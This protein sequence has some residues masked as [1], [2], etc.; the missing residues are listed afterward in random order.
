MS[1]RPPTLCIQESRW[2]RVVRG[3]LSS[4]PQRAVFV[5]S[6]ELSTGIRESLSL[7]RHR[8]LQHGG[9]AAVS[10]LIDP[11]VPSPSLLTQS[12]SSIS[13]H[14]VSKTTT[15][16][17][18]PSH[19]NPLRLCPSPALK[20]PYPQPT[21]TKPL[22][23]KCIRPLL[24]TKQIIQIHATALKPPNA[25]RAIAPTLPARGI[26]PRVRA[27]QSQRWIRC[28]LRSLHQ[29]HGH[30]AEQLHVVVRQPSACCSSVNP[31]HAPTAAAA[32]A[33]TGPVRAHRP[34]GAAAQPRDAAEDALHVARAAGAAGAVGEVRF[35]AVGDG[36]GSG[37]RGVFEW[38]AAILEGRHRLVWVRERVGGREH[39]GGHVRQRDVEADWV[40]EGVCDGCGGEGVAGCLLWCVVWDVE[41]EGAGKGG[42]GGEAG[43]CVEEVVG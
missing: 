5:Q 41:V 37:G 19:P 2:C 43:G 6:S 1:V 20:R 30:R 25:I 39:H 11:A 13:V 38:E 26:R 36:V 24:T 32:V 40:E 27:L 28:V 14:P 9:C 23:Q 33:A 35:Q 42:G 15:L 10:A 34:H 29:I 22:I 4:H 31:G 7:E 21:E 18:P 12:T 17:P 16:S 8:T 3:R